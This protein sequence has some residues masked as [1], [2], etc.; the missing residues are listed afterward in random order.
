ML[1]AGAALSAAAHVLAAA[2]LFALAIQEV[3]KAK[4]LRSALE[5]HGAR[6]DRIKLASILRHDLK[7]EA[8]RSLLGDDA[9]WITRGSFD[10]GAFDSSFDIGLDVAE[11]TRLDLLYV[12]YRNG[13]WLDPPEVNAGVLG[14]VISRVLAS[15]GEHE[16]GLLQPYPQGPAD[17]DP[18]VDGPDSRKVLSA[19]RHLP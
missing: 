1:E 11:P 5:N 17:S 15:L 6:N 3:G 8:A 2:T 16:R 10:R 7:V 12:E 13:K 4:L 9:L 18:T 19:G 14:D